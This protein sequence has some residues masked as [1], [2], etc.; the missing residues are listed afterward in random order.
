MYAMYLRKWTVIDD[1]IAS[2]N[3]STE[4]P[5]DKKR[6]RK[7]FDGREFSYK[8]TRQKKAQ[9]IYVYP[10]ILPFESRTIMSPLIR[11][12]QIPPFTHFAQISQQ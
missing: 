2:L 1:W 4:E 6:K 12:R 7:K 9:S 8:K 3:R 11:N 5:V 10:Q